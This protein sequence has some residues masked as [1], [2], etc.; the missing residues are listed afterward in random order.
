[1]YKVNHNFFKEI[2]TEEQAY[3]L[4]LMY[5]DGC[6]TSRNNSYLIQFTQ[7]KDRKQLV[8][9][10]NN[11][12]GSNKPIYFYKMKTGK[13]IYMCSISSKQ[14]GEDLIRLGCTKKKSLTL[15]FPNFISNNLMPHFIRGIFDGDGCIW[16]GK[17]KKVEIKDKNCKNGKRIRIIHNV[18]FTFTGNSSFISD[19]QKFLNKECLLPITKLN[20]SKAKNI[21]NSTS[22]NICTVEYSGRKN[23]KKLYD[24]MYNQSHYYEINKYQKFKE[25]L[26][27]LVEKSTKDISLIA[28]TPEM[29]ISSQASNEEG[30]TTITEM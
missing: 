19:L 20:Y 3:C 10:F 30:S 25:I 13:D 21:S 18:K 4:G 6:V 5:S 17:R 9:L 28:G 7:I 15:Q 27:A 22:N 24:Y 26:C 12:L 14:L 23:I 16:N 11:L 29:V 1:M 8:E 2:K